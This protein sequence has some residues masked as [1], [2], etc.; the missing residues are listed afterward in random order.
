MSEPYYEDGSVCLWQGDALE[1]LEGLPS[2]SVDCVVTSPPYY[3]LR[4]YGVDGQIG[5]EETPEG[6]VSRLAGVFREVGRV[7]RD[8]GTL[9]LNLADSYAGSGKGRRSDG[10]RGGTVGKQSTDRGSC[11]GRLNGPCRS[12]RRKSLLGIPWRVAFALMDDGW[13]L[14]SEIIWHASNKMPESVRDRPTRAHETVFLLSRNTSYH[15]DAEAVR[16]PLTD[17]SV[18]KLSQD[19]PSQQG[20][21]RVPGRG[22]GP[23]KAVNSPEGRNIRDV[24][25]INTTPFT[26]AHFATFP[27]ALPS[28]CIMAGCRPGGVVLDPFSGSGTTGLAALKSGSRYVGID[29]NPDYLELSLKTR[30]AQRTLEAVA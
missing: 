7:L 30:L 11:A 24:W 16:Q 5:L 1:V 25:D 8:D 13:I 26:G 19:V 2:G 9:W 29:I 14:R 18:R 27:E 12:V 17:S 22:N 4:D 28:T 6:Y 23:M 21:D 20:S 15:Y 10:T 3:G